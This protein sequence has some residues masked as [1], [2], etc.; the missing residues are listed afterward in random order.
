MPLKPSLQ[1]V[2]R[3]LDNVP[4]R[5]LAI[6]LLA[7]LVAALLALPR[8]Q[9]LLPTVALSL[10]GFAAAFSAIPHAAVKLGVKLN[11]VDLGKR[12]R[13]SSCMSHAD[14]WGDE[15]ANTR[16]RASKVPREPPIPQ[17]LGLVSGSAFLIALILTQVAH[18]DSKSKY[19]SMMLCVC[20]SI[21]LGLADDV[22]DIRWAHK[23]GLGLIGSLPLLVGYDGPTSIV[24]P[25]PLRFLV[26]HGGL[27]H[28]VA[29]LFVHPSADGAVLEL[30]LFYLAYILAL[31]VFCTNAINILAGINGIETGQTLVAAV[32]VAFMDA[33]EM[34]TSPVNSPNYANH[35]FSLSIML[36]FIATTLALC[37]HNWFPARV[38][39]GDVFP[40][41]AG[42]TF[43]ATSILGHYS[44]S[45]LLLLIP[46]VFNFCYSAPQ[47]FG[48]V[49]CPRHRLP[50]V[51]EKTHLLEPSK[52]APGDA[53][54][55]MTVLCLALRVFGT[56][57]E[58]SLT[59]VLLCAQGLCTCAGLWARAYLAQTF[60]APQ[61]AAA[62]V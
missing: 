49:P 46:Q 36:P 9:D 21:L 27:L 37:S 53:R 8:P 47:L 31:I 40:Y 59:I 10:A 58:R 18:P 56:M 20:F 23:I 25:G 51:N 30:G 13:P 28:E 62:E 44:R 24:V 2:D 12:A 43:A 57:R 41:Y 3:V 26:A 5:L 50:S 4:N 61:T 14:Q 17:S 39:V 35:Y 45:L 6:V 42:M 7:P 16:A 29:R 15:R 33:R 11:G 48:L 38:F 34:A 55:N 60:F 22:M 54:S 1:L 52:V 19:D 32:G